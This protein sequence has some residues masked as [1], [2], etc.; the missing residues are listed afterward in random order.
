[1]AKQQDKPEPE[2]IRL[3]DASGATVLD[4]VSAEYEDSFCLESFGDLVRLAED[5]DPA[6]TPQRFLIHTH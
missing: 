3:L 6:G 2:I 4:S 1:M 5:A